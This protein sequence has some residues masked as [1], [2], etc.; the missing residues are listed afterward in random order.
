M[1]NRTA[2]QCRE[3]WVNHIHPLLRK[4]PWTRREE[5]ILFLL[6]KLIGN[7]WCQMKRIFK[8]RSENDIKNRWYSK[9]RSKKCYYKEL[10][11]KICLKKVRICKEN[12]F[13]LFEIFLLKRIIENL[14]QTGK[15]S[16]LSLES[17]MMVSDLISN[18]I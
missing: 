12:G 8:N 18:L 14:D 7:K 5:W 15:K 9:F 3:R 2:K 16:F 11:N 17:L 6:Q 13:N 1:P 4:K 10:L